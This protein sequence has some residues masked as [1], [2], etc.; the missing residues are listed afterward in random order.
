MTPGMKSSEMYVTVIGV[1][2]GVA[3]KVFGWGLNVEELAGVL[4]PMAF[5]VV[6]RGMAKINA[7]SS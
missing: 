1:L 7:S 6:S 5:Y 3:N 4:A 2:I